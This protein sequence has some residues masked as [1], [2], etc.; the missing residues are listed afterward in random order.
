M[1]NER[2]LSYAMSQKLTEDELHSVSAAGLTYSSSGTGTYSGGQ[3]DGNLDV[4]VD[5]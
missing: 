3:W 5:A 2:I 1:Q 4:T